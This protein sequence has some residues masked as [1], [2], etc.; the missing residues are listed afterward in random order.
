MP[1]PTLGYRG[2][3]AKTA[4]HGTTI[5]RKNEVRTQLGPVLLNLLGTNAPVVQLGFDY[6]NGKG[7]HS[8]PESGYSVQK[9]QSV[10]VPHIGQNTLAIK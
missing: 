4:A 2:L 6:L 9:V 10:R 1:A 3:S 8:S 5:L 7:L